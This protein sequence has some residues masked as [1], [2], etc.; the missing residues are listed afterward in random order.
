MKSVK[1]EWSCF[2]RTDRHYEANCQFS[3][4]FEHAHN[5]SLHSTV[6]S[7]GTVVTV[8]RIADCTETCCC[9]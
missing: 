1:W 8:G 7:V 9:L 5:Y 3:Q 2:M 4:F 6:Q